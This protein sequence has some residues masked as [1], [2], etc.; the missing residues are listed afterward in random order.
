MKRLAAGMLMAI[1]MS[2][3]SGDDGWSGT[4]S[5]PF[6]QGCEEVMAVAFDLDTAFANDLVQRGITGEDM[7]ECSLERLSDLYGEDDYLAMTETEQTLVG[8][9]VGRLCYVDLSRG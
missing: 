8:D 4:L 1:V 7:C 6:V 3:C 5:T 2:G 9:G